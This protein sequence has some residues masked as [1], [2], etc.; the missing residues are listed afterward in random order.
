MSS[1]ENKGNLQVPSLS[2]RSWKDLKAE[3]LQA[4]LTFGAFLGS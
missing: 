1:Q 4:N 3:K 2:L